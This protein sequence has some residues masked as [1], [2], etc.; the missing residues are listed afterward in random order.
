MH[1][2]IETW[3]IFSQL[4]LLPQSKYENKKISYKTYK[5]HLTTQ[6]LCIILEKTKE[7][8]RLDKLEAD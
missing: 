3:K 4:L 7:I 8:A 6:V 1:Q 5:T 2:S